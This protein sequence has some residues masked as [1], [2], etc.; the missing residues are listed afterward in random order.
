MIKYI[1]ACSILIAALVSISC[2]DAK[3]KTA[4]ENEITDTTLIKRLGADEYG[5]RQYVIAFLKKGPNRNQ[6]SVTATQLQDAHMK[7]I[8][9]MAEEG[10]LAIAGPF[11]D[12]GELRGIYIFSVATVEEAKALTESDPAIKA[13]RLSMELHPWYGSAALMKVNEIHKTIQVKGF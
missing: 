11:M 7:N 13:G 1:P 6:D 4:A 8:N 2:N 3:K 5:M 12:T 9:R 10:K